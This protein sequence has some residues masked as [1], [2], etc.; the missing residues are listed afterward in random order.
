MCVAPATMAVS[1]KRTGAHAEPLI[2]ASTE[3]NVCLITANVGSIFEIV[4][5]PAP[6]LLLP[7]ATDDG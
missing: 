6:A 3:G 1:H 7:R 2:S 5:D 4:S